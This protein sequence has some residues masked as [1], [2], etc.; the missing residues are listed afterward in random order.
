MAKSKFVN[1][2][3]YPATKEK[4]DKI[5]DATG[6]NYDAI[7]NDLLAGVVVDD[8]ETYEREKVFMT[9]KYI[10]NTTGKIK[11]REVTFKELH[12]ARVGQQ[13][14]AEFNPA[15]RNYINSWIEVIYN[16]VEDVVLMLNECNSDFDG[17]MS[18]NSTLIHVKMF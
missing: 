8:V 2:A 12:E 9:L 6:K 5:K 7:L 14:G 17:V 15:E 4:V 10:D 11:S 16:Q 3:V 1:I 18:Y 13:F